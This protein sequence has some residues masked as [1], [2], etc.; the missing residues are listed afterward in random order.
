[1]D[2]YVIGYIISG[3][4]IILAIIIALVAQVRVNSAFNEYNDKL[5]SLDMT[6]AELA[7]KLSNDNNMNLTVRMCGGHLSDHYDQGIIV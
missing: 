5:S 4:V 1:M 7:Q 6:G 3:I 2:A